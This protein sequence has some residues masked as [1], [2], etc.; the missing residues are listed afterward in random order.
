MV[1]QSQL[2]GSENVHQIALEISLLHSE[3]TTFVANEFLFV[4]SAARHPVIPFHRFAG[5][6]KSE[7]SS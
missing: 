4:Q 7:H 6:L 3:L 5:T 2:T 1:A